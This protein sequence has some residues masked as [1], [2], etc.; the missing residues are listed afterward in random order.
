MPIVYSDYTRASNGSGEAIRALV[1]S[2]R[3]IG[4]MDL[5]VDS[6]LN[7]PTKFI[8][9]CGDL[10]IETGLFD[11]DSI[12]IFYAQLVGSIIQIDEFAPGYS[13]VGNAIGQTV[14][15][16]P[17]TPWADAVAEAGGGTGSGIIVSPTAPPSPEEDD[18]WLDETVEGDAGTN[19]FIF[20]Q[21]AVGTVNGVNTA[22]SVQNASYQGSSLQVFINGLSQARTIHFSEGSPSTGTFTF[23]SAPVTGDIITVNYQISPA[24]ANNADTLDNYHLTAI[25]EAI[26]PVGAVYVSTTSTMPELIDD[27]GTWSRV[28]GRVIVGL[29]EGQTEFDTP[30]ETGGHKLLQEHRHDIRGTARADTIGVRYSGNGGGSANMSDT[31]NGVNADTYTGV[32]KAWD[33]GGGDSENLQPYKVKY[34]WERTA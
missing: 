32:L 20:S 21:G 12:T 13:D 14:L 1:T 2:P 18:F 22:F 26:Y 29:D 9:T 6:V 30:D 23:T 8:A 34:M 31:T 3:D 17:T 28:L 16:K 27:I 24:S 10:D 19:S 5:I 33:T 7:Y 11:P 4:D 25:L 15:L